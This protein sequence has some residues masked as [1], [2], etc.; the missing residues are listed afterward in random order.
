MN[1]W[2]DCGLSPETLFANEDSSNNR[3]SEVTLDFL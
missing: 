2:K 3:T 1:E